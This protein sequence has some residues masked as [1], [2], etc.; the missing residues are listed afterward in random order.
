[1]V[2]R[3]EMTCVTGSASE[4]CSASISCHCYFSCC[5]GCAVFSTFAL[6]LPFWNIPA[7]LPQNP[8]SFLTPSDTDEAASQA[9]SEHWVG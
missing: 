5:H 2:E 3:S 1:M 7:F 6:W 9:F 4:G 8:S